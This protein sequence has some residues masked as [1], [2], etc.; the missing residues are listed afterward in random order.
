MHADRTY[1]PETEQFIRYTESAGLTGKNVFAIYETE[2]RVLWVGTN[3]GLNAFDPETGTFSAYTT[4]DGL[5]SAYISGILED[6]EGNL[7]FSTT[8]GISTFN[9]RTAILQHFDKTVGLQKRDFFQ[10]SAY[11]AH[12]VNLQS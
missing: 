5:P 9:P 3:G 2:A 4:K 11:K 7:W 10:E 1:D 6:A 12:D 8:K